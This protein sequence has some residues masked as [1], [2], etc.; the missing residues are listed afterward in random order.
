MAVILIL[1]IVLAI[2]DSRQPTVLGY[3]LSFVLTPSMEP[4]IEAGDLIVS[5][6][7]KPADLEVGDIITFRADIP[8]GSSQPEKKASPIESFKSKK[9]A[10]PTTLQPKATTTTSPIRG[11]R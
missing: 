7:V 2:K 10:E 5:R 9:S 1:Q 4:A 6:S 8:V 3:S 11:K